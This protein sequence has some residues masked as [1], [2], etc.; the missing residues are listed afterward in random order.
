M[1]RASLRF[2]WKGISHLSRI[3][4][5]GAVLLTLA[6]GGLMLG[7][8]YWVLPDIERYHDI[9]TASVSKNIGQPVSVGK[10]EAD[11]RGLHPHLLLTDVLIMDKQGHGALALSHVDNV[12]SWMTLLTGEVRLESL[13]LDQPNLLVKRDMQGLL[14]I[15]GMALSDKSSDKGLADWLLHQV[16]IVVRDARI[17]WQDEQRTTSMLT[18]DHV[19]LFIENSGP[20][21]RFALR[22]QPPA[23]L[24]AQIEVRG[25]FSGNNFEELGAWRG[26]LFTRLDYADVSAWRTWLPLPDGFKRGVGALRGWINIEAGKIKR[27]TADLALANVQA[28]LAEDLPPLDLR[29]LRGRVAWQETAQGHEVSTRKLSLQ[30]NNGLLLQPTDFFLRFAAAR[31]AQ[32]AS[33]EMRVNT[34]ELASLAGMADYLPLERNLK[35]QLAEF[36]PQGTVS[37]LQAKWQAGADKLAHYD[38]KAHFDQL[39]MRRVGNLP[40]FSGLSGEVDGSDTSGTLLLNA[41]KLTV[42]A[43]QIMP[44]PLAFDTLTAQSSWKSGKQ[45]M[46]IKFS[47]VSVANEDIAGNVFGSFQTLPH[48]PGLIDLNI[49]L[50]RGAVRHADRYIPL[51]ALDKETHAWIRSALLDGQ[52]DE[53]RLHLR[54]DLNDFPFPEN[55]KGIFQI[56]MRAK[57][58]TVEYAKEWPRLYNITGDLLIQGKRLEVIA[59]TAMTVGGHLQK[60]SVVMPDMTSPDLLLQVRGEALDET[61]RSLDFIQKSPVRG[62][63]D[64]FTDDMTARGYGKLNLHVDIPLLGSKPVTVSGSYR[65]V[66]NEVNLGEG[67]PVLYKTN[68]ELLFTESSMHT[69]NASAQIFG[70]P[71]T[72]AVQSDA[73]G[74]VQAKVRGK[75]DMDSLRKIVAHPLL[76]SLHGGSDWEA[77]ITMQKKLTEV[78]VTSDLIGLVSDLPAPFTKGANEAIPLRYRMKSVTAQQDVLSLQYGKLLS[79]RLLRRQEGGEWAIKRGTVNFGNNAKW[80]G[81]DGIWIT[82]AIPQLS[83]KG[84]WSLVGASA[85]ETAISIAGVDLSIQSLNVYGYNVSDLQLS[86]RDHNGT[87]TAQLAAKAVNGEISWETEGKGKLTARLKNLS[88]VKDESGKKE[89][90]ASKPA[91]ADIDE[92]AASTEFPT[93]DLVVDD[94]TWK[95]KPLGKLELLAQQH[96]RDWL[97]ERMR[98]INPD[99]VL[100]A[101]GKWSM[102]TGKAQTQV[103]LNLEISDAGKILTRSGYPNSVKNGSGKLDGV[104]IWRGGPKDFSYATLDGALK[105]DTGKGQFLKI[106][107]G[108]GKLLGILSLQALPKHITL[109]F[110]DVFSEGFSFDSISGTVQIKQGVLSTS[111]FKM[112]GSSAKVTMAGQVDLDRETQNLRIRILPTV[113]NS[114]SLL[115]AFTAGPAVGIGTFIVN[116]LLREPLDKLASFEYHVTGNWDNPNVE[117]AGESKPAA[118]ERK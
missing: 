87:L 103:N 81:K 22:A 67:A 97:L 36:A 50:T 10:I 3:V 85:G 100:A 86:A 96:G 79:A 27:L 26:Q 7:L 59:P 47:N 1:L 63:I 99:G 56:Q 101:D 115:G 91:A 37:A 65:F 109:D 104:F 106:D 68:G 113:G 53:F 95:G 51:A 33:G 18:F 92:S 77:A 17:T 42:D 111:D 9:I 78:T 41:R 49:N 72:L 5:I 58:V 14:Y 34:L 39:S 4:L 118:T 88:L 80:P 57:G 28:Q 54:G 93:L 74:I 70:G 31:D 40:G 98:I 62:Y 105:L 89:D 44:E 43:P 12:V 6:I 48:S 46:E 32:P 60:V 20:H 69:R 24:S 13:E 23:E 16:S 82:G 45:G 83:L 94:F 108:I 11:W 35:K 71:A 73:D 2:A 8:R 19:N 29:A 76:G 64:G 114:V 30:M 15:A 117:K 90:A 84:W 38:V 52:A 110:T 102:A 25:D 107:P 75:A 112:D 55:R 116:K 61:A 66:D 21:H